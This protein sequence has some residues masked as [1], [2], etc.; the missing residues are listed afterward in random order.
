MG[1]TAC[2]GGCTVLHAPASRLVNNEEGLSRMTLEAVDGRVPSN[3]GRLDENAMIA[4]IVA[5]TRDVVF[6]YRLAP[7]AVAEYVSPGFLAVTGYTPDEFYADPQLHLRLVHPDDRPLLEAAL[8]APELMD[9]LPVVRLTRKDGRPVWVEAALAVVRDGSAAPLW[10]EGIL[11]DVTPREEHA[12]R[13][14]LVQARGRS[15]DPEADRCI[16]IMVVDDHELTRAGLV[17][18]VGRDPQLEVVGEASNGR[19]ALRLA[20]TLEPDLV[21]M[22]VRM[23]EMDGLEATQELKKLRPMTSVLLLTMFDDVD[24]LVR[25]VTAGGAGYVLKD[26]SLGEIQRAIRE[27]ASGGF[28]VD[29]R[30]ARDVLLRVARQ[31][32]P[33]PP[34]VLP[35]SPLTGRE[36]EVLTLL[37]SGGTNREIGEA[38]TITPHT[39]KNHVEHIL[40]KLGVSDRT[41]AAVRAIELGLAAA[42]PAG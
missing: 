28:P 20:Q 41:Q 38:L 5:H 23:P 10:V 37:A 32:K 13:L 31:A 6:R 30:L 2:S 26:S 34:A 14:E 24:L 15:G 42:A 40:A 1:R 22:D 7:P 21:L 29:P 11:R 35:L 4:Q 18:I 8:A 36:R 27:V 25:A 9:G 17:A 39:V 3:D 16:R 12:R 33:Q 19:A